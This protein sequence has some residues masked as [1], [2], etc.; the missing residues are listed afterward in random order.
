[1]DKSGPVDD[2]LLVN[3]MLRLLYLSPVSLIEYR[4]YGGSSKR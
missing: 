3:N 2:G 1:M 4:S